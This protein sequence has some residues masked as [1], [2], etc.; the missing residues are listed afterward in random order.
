MALFTLGQLGGVWFFDHNFFCILY[1]SRGVFFPF[2]LWN[3]FKYF[4]I[5]WKFERKNKIRV[6][7]RFN[8]EMTIFRFCLLFFF[9]K[10]QSTSL[11]VCMIIQ[12]DI[13]F[14]LDKLRP[15]TTKIT[16]TNDFPLKWTRRCVFSSSN[17]LAFFIH[18]HTHKL[19]ILSSFFYWLLDIIM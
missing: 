4:W 2:R 7:N 8:F 3:G 17:E 16:I 6:A 14:C 9:S 10:I 5:E 15:T 18:K 13:L 1:F 12:M 11:S 19:T